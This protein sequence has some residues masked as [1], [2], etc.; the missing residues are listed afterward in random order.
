MI[1]PYGWCHQTTRLIFIRSRVGGSGRSPWSQVL[2]VCPPTNPPRNASLQSVH[3]RPNC[4]RH[5]QRASMAEIQSCCRLLLTSIITGGRDG[6]SRYFTGEQRAHCMM[7]IG[8]AHCAPPILII[9]PPH[10]IRGGLLWYP[11]LKGLPHIAQGWTAGERGAVLPWGSVRNAAA[12]PE[13]VAS[14]PSR[15]SGEV[16]QPLSGLMTSVTPLPRVGSP[17][18]CPRAIQPRAE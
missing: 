5:C 15:R 8:G 17:P 7:R 4:L 12:N 18:L 2:P 3:R 16:M 9:H 1:L 10:H 13:R 6:A 14:L 11:I